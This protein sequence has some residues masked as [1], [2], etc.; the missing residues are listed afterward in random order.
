MSARK[1][2]K[3]QIPQMEGVAQDEL[4]EGAEDHEKTPKK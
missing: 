2:R 1:L 4:E 3:I